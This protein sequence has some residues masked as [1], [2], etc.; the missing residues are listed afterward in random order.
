MDPEQERARRAI[1]EECRARYGDNPLIEDLGDY[2]PFL[3]YFGQEDFCRDQIRLAVGRLRPS[4]LCP[5]P[6]GPTPISSNID[7]LLGFIELARLSGDS[8]YLDPGEEIFAAVERAYVRGGAVWGVYPPGWNRLFR[9]VNNYGRVILEFALDFHDLTGKA[10]YLETA[11]RLADS[12]LRDRFFRKHGFFLDISGPLRYLLAPVR[13][14]RWGMKVQKTNNFISGLISLYEKN[15]NPVIADALRRYFSEIRTRLF[16]NGVLHSDMNLGTGRLHRPGLFTTFLT[17]DR[18]TH[19]AYAFQDDRYLEFAAAVADPWLDRQ[20]PTGLFPYYL[21][22]EVSWLDSETDFSIS[23]L[24][25]HELTAR[26]RYKAAADAC[27]YGTIRHN[28]DHMSV[29]VHTGDPAR[30]LLYRT[31]KEDHGR[32]DTKYRALFL[33]LMACYDSDRLIFGPGGLFKLI[34]DR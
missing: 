23:L 5:F 14:N 10:A 15:R 12:I 29:D 32:A 33:K 28:L 20:A 25:L 9:R 34:R 19:A 22:G 11:E 21:D 4:W 27:Y 18:L 16:H 2:L 7:M 26:S 1:V 8:F 30:P 3:F 13:K 24:R 31:T 17:I 6:D